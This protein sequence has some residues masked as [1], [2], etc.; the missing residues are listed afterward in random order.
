METFVATLPRELS[1]LGELRRDLGAWLDQTEL[2]EELRNAIILS[3]HEA[4]ANAIEH[5]ETCNAVEIRAA[6]EEDELTVA[7]TDAGTWKHASF[8]N[9]ERGRGLMMISVLMPHVEIISKPD[10]TTIRMSAPL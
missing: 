2:S 4:A 9:D 7:V 5:A 1:R 8:D 3:T 6:I 10:G